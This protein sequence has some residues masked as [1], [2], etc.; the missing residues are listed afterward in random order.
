MPD[1]LAKGRMR[2]TIDDVK[3]AIELLGKDPNK[4]AHSPRLQQAPATFWELHE[5]SERERTAR[6]ERLQ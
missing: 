2:L 4:F 1:G 6:R 3:R 5:Q